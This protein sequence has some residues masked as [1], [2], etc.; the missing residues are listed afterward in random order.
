MS[1]DAILQFLDE[2]SEIALDELLAAAGLVRA[3]LLELVDLG[4]FEPRRGAQ[5]GASLGDPAGWRF[6]YGLKDGVSG[7]CQSCDLLDACRGGCRSF[8]RAAAN[9]WFA[10]DPRCSGEPRA[11]GFMPVCFMLR[12]NVDTGTRSG[13]QEHV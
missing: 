6:Y 9:D 3:E 2:A 13:F 7:A 1:D 11:Q 10:L 5:A 4:A 12:E 8:S